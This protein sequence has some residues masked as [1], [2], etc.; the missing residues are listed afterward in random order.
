MAEQPQLG[1]RH[2]AIGAHAFGRLDYEL[3]DGEVVFKD[4]GP[5]RVMVTERQIGQPSEPTIIRARQLR[6]VVAEPHDLGMLGSDVRRQLGPVAGAVL[7]GR[8]FDQG[9]WPRAKLDRVPGSA[10]GRRQRDRD[11]CD[12]LVF[13]TP[14]IAR[15]SSRLA[16]GVLGGSIVILGGAALVMLPYVPG[17]AAKIALVTLGAALPPGIYGIS[18]AVVAE[19]TPVAQRGALLAIGTAV[20]GSAGLLAPYIMGSVIESAATPLDGFNTGFF[21]CGIILLVGGAITMAL[22][23]PERE[24]KRQ[25][26]RLQ[27]LTAAT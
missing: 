6:P 11:A 22:A 18:H 14:A 19:I 16:R 17:T 10:G 5:I 3:R 1:I 7:A 20:A 8:L 24:A 4:G 9:P 13:A 21:M 2:D 26:R 23:N 25:S 27:P 12:R 15:L